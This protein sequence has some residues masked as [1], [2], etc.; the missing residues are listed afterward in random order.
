VFGWSQLDIDPEISQNL[1]GVRLK[2]ARHRSRDAAE[3]E[4]RP[5]LLA[6]STIIH[7]GAA[8]RPFDMPWPIRGTRADGRRR[9]CRCRAC[10]DAVPASSGSAHHPACV[11]PSCLAAARDCNDCHIPWRA[12]SCGQPRAAAPITGAA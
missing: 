8:V 7:R 10:T 1:N 5:R 2:P 6:T 11:R 4:A 9:Q 3:P 12:E